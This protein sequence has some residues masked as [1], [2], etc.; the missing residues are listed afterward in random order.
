M[1]PDPQAPLAPADPS[2]GDYPDDWYVPTGA[3]ADTPYPNDWYVPAPTAASSTTPP[4]P[5]AQPNPADPV[6]SKPPA[7]RPDPFAAYWSRIPA[8]R[9]GAMAWHPPIF[10]PPNPLSPENIPASKW[11]T[12]PPIFPDSLGQFPL[13]VPA[14]VPPIDATGGLLGAL[15]NLRPNASAYGL[16]GA[17]ANLLPSNACAPPFQRAE[18][19]VGHGDQPAPPSLLQNFSN[20]TWPS[21]PSALEGASNSASGLA[22]GNNAGQGSSP[23]YDA[24][25]VSLGPDWPLT[26]P[27]PESP[28][29]LPPPARSGTDLGYGNPST[30]L[31]SAAAT[32]VAPPLPDQVSAGREASSLV[33]T[34]IGQP[35]P[36]DFVDQTPDLETGLTPSQT[37][38]AASAIGRYLRINQPEIARIPTDIA[39]MFHDAVTDFPEFMRRAEPGF[40]GLGMSVPM[41]RAARNVWL[42]NDTLRGRIAEVVHGRN[43]PYSF[44]KV[45]N[46]ANGI[47]TG[48]KSIN[49]NAPYY[50]QAKSLLSKLRGQINQVANFAGGTAE[51]FTIEEHQI[52]GRALDVLVP[53]S[54]SVVQKSAIQ[55]AIEYGARQ[56]VTVNIIRHQ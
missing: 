22:I 6:A 11:V 38:A 37:S 54:G 40:A 46:F 20:P 27:Q 13:T 17:L 9:A 33:G 51:G 50:Q 30:P 4:V 56:G 21:P 28:A 35:N 1:P 55:Q 24:L 10:P 52:A 16:L 8:S 48:I 42:L 32:D 43:L 36:A 18:L 2:G 14:N 19:A 39:D 34:G 44:P 3:R 47:V 7:A 45:D 5:G 41:T 26:S 15:A 29:L 49:L 31:N 23:G 53:H 25:G 12:S